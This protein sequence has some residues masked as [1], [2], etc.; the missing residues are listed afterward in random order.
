LCTSTIRCPHRLRRRLPDEHQRLN[1]RRDAVRERRT[2]SVSMEPEPD[3]LVIEEGDLDTLL[4][5]PRSVLGY[6]VGMRS[7][8]SGFGD[9][10]SGIM[11]IAWSGEVSWSTLPMVI[12]AIV[13]AA[14]ILVACGIVFFSLALWLGKVETARTRSFKAHCA[15]R[16]SQCCPQGSSATYQRAWCRPLPFRMSFCWR[17]VLSRTWALP[18][19]C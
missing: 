17:V 11:F 12:G 18:L 6:A 8:P 19:R 16:S 4:T 13:A 3:Q 1:Q 5:Q 15:S 9:V 7:Q 14:L 10:L 2:S